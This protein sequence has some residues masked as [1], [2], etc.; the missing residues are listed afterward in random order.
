MGSV[1]P[2]PESPVPVIL[3]VLCAA[4]LMQFNAAS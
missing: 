1:V 3:C 4:L 2:D